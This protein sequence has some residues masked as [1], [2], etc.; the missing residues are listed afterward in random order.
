MRF[1]LRIA[2]TERKCLRIYLRGFN[3]MGS[4]KQY[5]RELQCFFKEY[6][7]LLKFIGTYIVKYYCQIQY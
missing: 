2:N 5:L 3:S 7:G 4:S 1:H 6:P